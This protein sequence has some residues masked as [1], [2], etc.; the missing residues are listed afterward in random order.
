MAKRRGSGEGSIFRRTDGRWCAQI[1]LPRGP[2]GKRRR[3]TIYGNRRSDVQ[4]Q[5][6]AIRKKSDSGH[7]LMSDARVTVAQYST[8][9]LDAR[10]IGVA[11][12]TWLRDRSILTLH[13]LPQI[14]HIKLR[15][16]TPQHISKMLETKSAE[17]SPRS[18]AHLLGTVKKMLNRAVMMNLMEYNPAYRVQ[19]PRVATTQ[20]TCFTAAEAQKYLAE[21][22][23]HQ[24]EAAFML[25]LIHGMRLGEILG[26]RWS[27][28]NWEQQSLSITTSLAQDLD[29][30]FR[31]G[32]TKNHRSSR[33][34][35]LADSVMA[36]LKT[37]RKIQNAERLECGP[38]WVDNDLVFA[39]SDGTPLSKTNFGRAYHYPLIHRA[40][41]PRITFHDLRHTAATLG[42]LAGTN[43]KVI[44]EM[45]GH[46]SISVTMDIYSHVMPSTHRA[47]GNAIAASVGL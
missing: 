9:W 22:R 12:S 32:P 35:E 4:D 28:V 33:P 43:P 44:Q 40:G 21:A 17:M 24:F 7:S 5:L 14:G 1:E 39:R 19:K 20:R 47:A 36:S 15:A 23:G 37:R 31:L 6:L 11:P 3:K 45:L 18:V 29:G 46:K 26:L 34:I 41:V 30:S 38:N 10:R 2:D 16:L 27:N 25:A 13:V 8:E 42:L